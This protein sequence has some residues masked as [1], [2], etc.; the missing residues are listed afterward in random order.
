MRKARI[1]RNVNAI[2]S[3]CKTVVSTLTR[4]AADSGTYRSVTLSSL[5]GSADITSL[6]QYFTVTKVQYDY[7]LINAPNNNAN[8]PTLY[9]APQHI[10]STGTPLSRDEVLQF[11]GVREYQFGPSNLKYSI[12]VKPKIQFDAGGINASVEGTGY[13]S[14]AAAAMPFITVVDWLTRYS[15]A[16][17]THTIDLVTRVW[18]RAKLTR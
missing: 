1:P 14:N 15:V 4:P 18:L 12:T 3:L 2:Q 6:F 10:T 9:V 13:C 11:N 7:V 8:F 5:P 16:D 17:P